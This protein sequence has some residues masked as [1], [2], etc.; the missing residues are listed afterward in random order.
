[1]R[2]LKRSTAAAELILIFPA[3]L[4]MTS[5]FVRELTPLQLEP[6]RTA[7]HIITWYASHPRIGLWILLIALPFAVL[8]T[9]CVMLRQSWNTDAELRHAAH[10][11]LTA[12]RAHWAAFFVLAATAASGI[13]LAIV[14]LHMATH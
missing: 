8:A 10:S 3:T 14:A 2:N 6:A 4:F 13:V 12:L 7:A 9:G 11:V 5:L 1:M